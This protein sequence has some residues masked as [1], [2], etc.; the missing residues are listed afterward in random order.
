ML[1]TINYIKSDFYRRFGN[2]KFAYVKF[3]IYFF[4]SSSFRFQVYFRLASSSFLVFKILGTILYYCSY[5]RKRIQIPIGTKIGYGFY[6]AHD[7][8]IVI[9]KKTVIG[10]NCNI[11][12]FC[13][14]G[15]NESEGAVIG[16]NTYIGPNC[17]IVDSVKIGD[18]VT[19]GA[20]SVVTKDLPDNCTAVGNYAKVINYNNPARYIYNRVR[21]E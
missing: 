19:I 1:T 2:I 4:Y 12:Q 7:G 14:I 5:T 13:T 15:T 10:N 20:G 21:G 17:C 11:S 18:N 6:I 8:Y 16:N 9:N 3:M